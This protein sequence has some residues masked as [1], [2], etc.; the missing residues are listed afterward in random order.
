MTPP[1]GR[2]LNPAPVLS[3]AERA[4]DELWAMNVREMTYSRPSGAIR[5]RA[6]TLIELLVVIA[7]IAIL[8]ALLLPALARAKEKAKR[9]Q[10]LNNLKQV[11]IGMVIYSTDNSDKVVQAR[12]QPGQPSFVQLALDVPDAN[13]MGTV[14]LN[15]QSNA[16]IWTCPNRPTLPNYD[17]TYGQWNIGYQYFGGITNW[18]NPLGQF[19]GLSP[20]K[21]SQA[22]PHWAL[23]ADAVVETEGG[24]GGS[25]STDPNLYLNLPPHRNPGTSFPAGGNEVFSDGSGRWIT[26]DKMRFLTTWDTV[27]R[28]CYFYQDRVDF[29][30]TLLLRLDAAY[31][32]P[33]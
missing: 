28:K 4:E 21:L 2:A 25:T 3:I 27:N 1:P 19:P 11:A 16:N 20:V 5:R 32:T 26:A 15:V 17:P 23:A 18:L 12:P 30:S 29:P 10:C 22:R 8:A 6:F 9:I 33:Q 14:N 31:M 24:W 7:I 13:G